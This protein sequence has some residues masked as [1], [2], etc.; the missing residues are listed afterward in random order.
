MPG[1]TAV[2]PIPKG[3][4]I[5]NDQLA[6]NNE[7]LIYPNPA[8]AYINLNIET[9]IGKGSI[10]VTDLY[11]KVAKT[12]LLSMGTNTVNISN[13]SKGFYLVSIITSEGKTTK[14]LIVE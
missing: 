11:G 4:A 13:L 10:V 1:T 3:V 5:G 7:F 2:C 12:Q 8:K 14:K 6:I 9:L